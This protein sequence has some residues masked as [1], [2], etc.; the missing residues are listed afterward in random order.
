MIAQQLE[1]F[2]SAIGQ[3]SHIRHRVNG[4]V[5]EFS[6]RQRSYD[7]EDRVA[8]IEQNLR[9]PQCDEASSKLKQ[10][11]KNKKMEKQKAYAAS[12]DDKEIWKDELLRKVR[13]LEAAQRALDVQ[14]KKISAENDALQKEV[15]RLRHLEQLRSV[16]AV[17]DR[18]DRA[19]SNT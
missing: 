1:V 3:S 4:Q 17:S 12:T 2:K 16:P 7:L 13:E 18:R 9:L 15:G 10:S 19:V 14:S 11:K 6:R 5:T 8:N